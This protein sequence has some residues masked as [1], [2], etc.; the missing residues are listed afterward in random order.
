MCYHNRYGDTRGGRMLEAA[1]QN[2][3]AATCMYYEIHVCMYYEI[4][5]VLLVC[6]HR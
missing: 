2:K 6:T 4:T 5:L 1:A 3:S